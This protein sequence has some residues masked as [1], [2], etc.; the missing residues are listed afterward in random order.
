VSRTAAHGSESERHT[1]L[2]GGVL[3]M[4]LWDR[5]APRQRALE[6]WREAA[7]LVSTRWTLFNEA[8]APE[9]RRAFAS[10]VAALD[11]EE[12]AAAR[13]RRHATRAAA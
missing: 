11:A 4:S 10:Y 6:A 2:S 3:Q 1:I 8:D 12:A 7:E 9:R 5:T 13:I